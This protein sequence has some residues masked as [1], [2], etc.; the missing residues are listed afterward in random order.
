LERTASP[1]QRRTNMTPRLLRPLQV[2]IAAA[3]LC[4]GAWLPMTA[5]A[6]PVIFDQTLINGS[7]VVNNDVGNINN[8]L[9]AEGCRGF[10]STLILPDVFA[11]LAFSLSPAQVADVANNPVVG[12]FTVVASRDIGHKAG[13]TPVDFIVT[14]ADGIG[15]GNLFFNTIDTCP[16]GERGS[17]GFP[18]DLVCGPNFHTDVQATDTLTIAQ[19]DLQSMAANGFINVTLNPTGTGPGGA[20]V[21]R[22]KLFSFR[23]EIEVVPAAVPE[24]SVLALLALGLIALPF[25]RRR[26]A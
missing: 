5:V 16:A 15:I 25:S 17:A 6:A 3:A 23:L 18:A 8:C 11:P 12:R 2:V 21:G 20:E 4:L 22:L 1:S 24:P 26:R 9:E 13:A 14:T 7:A 19:A 10:N